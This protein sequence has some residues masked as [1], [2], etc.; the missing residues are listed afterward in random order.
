MLSFNFGCL[1]V[2]ITG[3]NMQ[4]RTSSSLKDQAPVQCLKLF[5]KAR[6]TTLAIF[7]PK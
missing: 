3:V 2:L 6:V 1:N 4:Q 5:L 7:Y